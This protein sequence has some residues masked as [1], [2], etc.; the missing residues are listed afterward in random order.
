[1][2]LKSFR[3]RNPYLIGVAS[4]VIIAAAVIGAYLVGV[5]HVFQPVYSMSGVFSDAG[6]IANT[7]PVLIGGVKAGR[8][9]KVHAVDDAKTCARRI[10]DPNVVTATGGCVVVDFVVNHGIHVGPDVHAAIVLETLLGNRALQLTGPVTGPFLESQPKASRV[11]PIDRTEVPF[12]IFDLTTVSTR[13]IQATDTAKLNQ[14]IGQLANVTG[15]QRDQITTLLTSVTQISDTLNARQSQVKE[16]IDRADRLSAQLADKDQTLVSLIDQSQ[17]ILSLIQRRRSDISAGL[18]QANA[19]VAELDRLI[20]TN[21]AA[22]DTL[23][24]A[25][26]PTISTVTNRQDSLNQALAAIAP[27]FYTQGLAVSHGP[28]ADVMIKALGPDLLQCSQLLTGQTPNNPLSDTVLSLCKSLGPLLTP[29]TR[30]V[31]G[32]LGG[33]PGAKP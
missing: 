16:L 26:H 25:I 33:L 14:L 1:M 23:L 18:T 4:V 22:L 29:A 8:V 17:G 28:W 5:L 30:I 2:A 7:D 6:G 11:V 9:T 19:T 21:K 24:N 10:P 15:G 3:D 12:D 13:N 31:N 32:V 27:G 20:T